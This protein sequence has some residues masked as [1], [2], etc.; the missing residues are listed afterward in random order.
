MRRHSG[1]RVA[2]ARAAACL[3]AAVRHA[4]ELADGDAVT[5]GI[6]YRDSAVVG[7]GSILFY[8]VTSVNACVESPKD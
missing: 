8:R 5:P 6:Q 4:A 7:A 3:T 2:F 1:T